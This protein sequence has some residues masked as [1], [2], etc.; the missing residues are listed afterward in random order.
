MIAAEK[1]FDAASE[2]ERLIV[3]PLQPN[4][5]KNWLEQFNGSINTILEELI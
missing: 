2:S 1:G 4:D 5:Y 3:R